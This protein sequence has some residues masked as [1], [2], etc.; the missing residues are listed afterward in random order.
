MY[1]FN[2]AI[3]SKIAKQLSDI[4]NRCYHKILYL[5]LCYAPEAGTLVAM[6]VGSIGE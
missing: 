3:A 2:P 5:H 6:I 1:S 4:L